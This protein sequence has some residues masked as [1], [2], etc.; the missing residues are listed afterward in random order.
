MG[1]EFR[2][3]LLSIYFTSLWCY[4]DQTHFCGNNRK[5]L[6]YLIKRT[7][8]GLIK[9]SEKG[10]GSQQIDDLQMSN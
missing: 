8:G 2:S 3:S 1:V 5:R 10:E 6:V 7:I 9:R 4:D